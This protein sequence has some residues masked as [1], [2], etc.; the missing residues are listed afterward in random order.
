MA[1][2]KSTSARMMRRSSVRSELVSNGAINFI[3][4]SLSVT[5]FIRI[6]LL[7]HRFNKLVSSRNIAALLAATGRTLRL[8]IAPRNQLICNAPGRLCHAHRSVSARKPR[9]KFFANACLQLSQ[10]GRI[11][12]LP[13]IKHCRQFDGRRSWRLLL[14]Y[15]RHRR[16]DARGVELPLRPETVGGQPAVQRTRRQSIKI[17]QIFPRNSP[18]T[19]QIEICIPGF[20]R[21]K[22]PNDEENPPA[23]RFVALK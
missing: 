15:I 16:D 8:E 3:R 7:A 2:S 4:N 13:A 22:R 5:S 23:K 19:I 18:E 1:S 14:R 11:T 9:R 21:V 17:R 12:L 10:I 6:V 20:K